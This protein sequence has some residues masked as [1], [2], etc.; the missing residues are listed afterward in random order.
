M[1][2]WRPLTTCVLMCD[3]TVL[4]HVL[5]VVVAA[6]LASRVSISKP[7]KSARSIVPSN[8]LAVLFTGH[9]RGGVPGTLQIRTHRFVRHQPGH[10]YHAYVSSKKIHL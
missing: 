6:S 9:A 3:V 8:L 7:P 1:R 2:G 5:P 10:V 4:C